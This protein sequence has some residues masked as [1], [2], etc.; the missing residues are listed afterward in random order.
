MWR[1][2]LANHSVHLW[3]NNLAMVHVINLLV[4]N[5]HRIMILDRSFTLLCLQHNLLFR[6]RQTPRVCNW[7][8]DDLSQKQM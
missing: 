4:S 5:L 2:E 1:L 3:C 7:V 8:A 6:A